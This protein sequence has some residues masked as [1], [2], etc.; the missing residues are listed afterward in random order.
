MARLSWPGWLVTLHTETNVPHWDVQLIC[1]IYCQ[2]GLWVRQFPSENFGK[3]NISRNFWKFRENSGNIKFPENLQPYCQHLL[4]CGTV[5]AE[6]SKN[7]SIK[8]KLITAGD[9]STNFKKTPIVH[10]LQDVG[11]RVDCNDDK[12][13]PP[14]VKIFL[15]TP[16]IFKFTDILRTGL[17][18]YHTTIGCNTHCKTTEKCIS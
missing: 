5:C 2:L 17:R 16:R 4:G 3:F 7:S 9:C 1:R 12:C 10:L 8:H 6:N 15:R 13:R 14:A 18:R 11:F